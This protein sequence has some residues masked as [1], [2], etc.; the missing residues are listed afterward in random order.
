MAASQIISAPCATHH[1]SS[2]PLSQVN[3]SP[4]SSPIAALMATTHYSQHKVRTDH[5][6]AYARAASIGVGFLIWVCDYAP[7]YGL[8]V[9]AAGDG[10][11][12]V[13]THDLLTHKRLAPVN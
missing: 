7:G 9:D 1:N 6:R 4:L 10:A 13:L 5:P 3:N 8:T 12:H 11:L 2:E